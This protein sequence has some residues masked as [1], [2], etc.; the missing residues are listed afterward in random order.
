MELDILRAEIDDVDAEMVRLFEKRMDIAAKI[1]E[2]KQKK[3]CAV[4]DPEREMR[5]LDALRN[6][7]REDLRDYVAELYLE[8]FRLSRE[9]QTRLM[10]RCD[11]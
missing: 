5:K 1:A 6:A 8:I 10:E 4:K 11:G 3:G 2:Y 9:H 7:S